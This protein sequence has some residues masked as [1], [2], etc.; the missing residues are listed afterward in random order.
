M[1]QK[2]QRELL[3]SENNAPPNPNN[4]Y[5]RKKQRYEENDSSGSGCSKQPL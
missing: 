4:S 2:L 5:V 3:D 1:K